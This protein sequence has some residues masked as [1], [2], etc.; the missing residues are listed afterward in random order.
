[1]RFA[2][3]Q[4]GSRGRVRGVAPTL[5]NT[6]TTLARSRDR[7]WRLR[8]GASRARLSWRRLPPRTSARSHLSSIVLRRSRRTLR[9]GM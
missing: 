5:R 3:A 4:W 1:M 8:A 2:R 7:H 9:L 6:L